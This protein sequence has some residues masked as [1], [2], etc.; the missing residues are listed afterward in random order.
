M[1]KDLPFMKF[2]PADFIADCDVLGASAKGAWITFICKAWMARSA[3]LTFKTAQWSRIF[4]ATNVEQTERLI[5]EIEEWEIGDVIR[6]D[7]G[8]V[9]LI[10]R[11][12]ERDL[13]ERGASKK[14]QSE[15]A[16]NAARIRWEKHNNTKR[17]RNASETHPKGNADA[18]RIDAIPESIVHSPE[19]RTKNMSSSSLDD[20]KSI[21]KYLN[22]KTG[23]DYR[24]ISTHLDLIRTRLKEP[25]VDVEGVRKMIDSKCAEWLH[26]AE[27]SKFLRPSTLF[28]KT[29]FGSYYDE[30]NMRPKKQ[31]MQH[32][33]AA[34]MPKKLNIP[35]PDKWEHLVTPEIY[36]RGWVFLC[37]NDHDLAGRVAAGECVVQFEPIDFE[38]FLKGG[39]NA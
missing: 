10:S 34:L 25:G 28:G 39:A 17:I 38:S 35:E 30:R 2:F 15:A 18:M 6:E 16:R 27:M 8:R 14:K 3:S 22:K 31:A 5:A 13:K 1:T 21:L 19:S 11:R 12:I 20:A 29:K 36:E 24:L 33:G 26:D 23:K 32:T 7:D 37:K 9:T 4:G